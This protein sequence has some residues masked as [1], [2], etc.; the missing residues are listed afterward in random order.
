VT[1]EFAVID[2]LRRLLPGPPAGETW[3]GDDAAVVMPPRGGLLLTADAVVE[4]VHVDL[5]VL[6][7]DDV[8]WK[9]MS[10]T[11]SD[12]AAMGCRPLYAL[13]T[14]CGP[15]DTDVD[16]LYVGVAEAIAAYE[17]PVVGGDLVGAPQLMVSVAVAGETAHRTPVLRAGA[18]PGDRVFVTG[19]LGRS[20][21]GLRL[22]RDGEIGDDH[23]LAL[24]HRRPV[25][26][27]AEGRAARAAGATAMVDVSDGLAADIGHLLDASGVGVALDFVPVADRA[28]LEEALGGG[29]DYELV[30]TA[31][32][33]GHVA[34]TFAEAGLRQPLG[35]GYCTSDPEERTLAGEPLPDAGWQHHFR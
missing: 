14:V 18:L 35:I 31:T 2:R 5:D 8:G 24:A 26:R 3:I 15:P 23:P 34:A 6:G 13:I 22:L 21:A 19:R 16:L 7:L 25:A 32:R 33:P 30:F 9:A 27:L 17:C 20:A 12:V 4:G 1:G 11:I 29:E 10:V 28:T